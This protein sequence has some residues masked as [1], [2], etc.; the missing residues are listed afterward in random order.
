VIGTAGRGGTYDAYG[1]GLANLVKVDLH[2]AAATRETTGPEENLELLAEGKIQIGFATLGSV[3]KALKDPER[4]AT[5]QQIRAIAPMYDTA[6][7]FV[8]ERGSEIRT[9]GD[10]NGKVVGVGPAGGTADSYVPQMLKALQVNATFRTG[11]WAGLG[12]QLAN[13]KIDVLA[14]AGGTPFP[15]LLELGEKIP[16]R[17]IS[18]SSDQ[19]LKV[20]LATPELTPSVVAIGV[21]PW[22]SEPYQSVGMFNFMLVHRELPASLV[23]A[24]LDALFLQTGRMVEF[25]PAAAETTPRNVARNNVLPFHGGAVAWYGRHFPQD[26]G[27]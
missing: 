13:K 18:L 19:A 9:L 23:T 22:Q 11:D 12:D 16:L 26:R 27:D 4:A 1:Q 3:L 24:L 2:L 8:V 21:Y 14:V 20:R 5:M 17:F 15:A 7:H 6:F 10:L 25:S